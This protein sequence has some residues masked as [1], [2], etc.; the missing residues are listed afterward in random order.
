MAKQTRVLSGYELEAKATI[1]TT[2]GLHMLFKQA[3]MKSGMSLEKWL[4]EAAVRHLKAPSGP[5]AGL[6]AR[7]RRRVERYIELLKADE[8]LAGVAARRIEQ[9]T[10]IAL[11]DPIRVEG[12]GKLNPKSGTDSTRPES[13]G[14]GARDIRG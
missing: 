3:A 7:D 12:E 4:E 8:D 1:R 6:P 14:D 2:Q 13:L 10:R 5:L 9:F 11:E